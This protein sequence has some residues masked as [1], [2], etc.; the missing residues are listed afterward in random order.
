MAE[1]RDKQFE[2]NGLLIGR[3]TNIIVTDFEPK[4]KPDVTNQDKPIVGSDGIWFG[5][6]YLTGN[7][8]AIDGACVG[9]SAAEVWGLFDELLAAWD[10]PEL[11]GETGA[12]CQLRMKMP[13]CK[14]VTVFGRPRECDPSATGTS[15]GGALAWAA[16]FQA[17]DPLY[18][19][20]VEH[21]VSLTLLP[22]TGGGF[23]FPLTFPATLAPVSG[24]P[25]AV[26]VLGKRDTYPIVRFNGPL[27]SGSL[28]DPIIEYP[29]LGLG[30]QYVG[31]IGVGDWVELDMRPW[32]RTALTRDG[33]SVAGDLAGS[34]MEEMALSPGS[35]EVAFKGYDPT[36][37]SSMTLTWRDASISPYLGAS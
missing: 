11:R 26:T 24:V 8:I 30:I 29:V 25:G 16:N 35:M 19:S 22:P 21:T 23:Q 15:E 13:G 27:T 36:G 34:S 28:V 1:L 33:G 31:S 5:R 18:Y 12:V 4:G 37:T 14:P 2:V 6:D 3:G 7:L 10:A 32:V 9:D 20:D 17:V